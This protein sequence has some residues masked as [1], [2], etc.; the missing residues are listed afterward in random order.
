MLSKGPVI[1][2]FLGPTTPVGYNGKKLNE[3]EGE[4]QEEKKEVNPMLKEAACQKPE[5]CEYPKCQCLEEKEEEEEE[6]ED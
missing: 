5:K 6:G 3:E 2:I 1:N 4:E